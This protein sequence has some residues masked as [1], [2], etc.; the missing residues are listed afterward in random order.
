MGNSTEI[1]TLDLKIKKRGIDIFSA[2]SGSVTFENVEKQLTKKSHLC[3]FQ[4]KGDKFYLITIP[5]EEL[6]GQ[7]E[8]IVFY[9]IQWFDVI[10]SKKGKASRFVVGIDLPSGE[11]VISRSCCFKFLQQNEPEGDFAILSRQKDFC[12]ELDTLQIE[13]HIDVKKQIDIWS[14]FIQAQELLIKKLQEPMQCAGSPKLTSKEEE[15]NKEPKKYKLEV[16]LIADKSNE[17]RILEETLSKEM[18]IG[19]EFHEDGSA[20]MTLDDILRGL[21]PIIKKYYS[22]TIA[23]DKKIN[24]ILSICP[25]LPSEI[26]QEKYGNMMD[27]H[28]KGINNSNLE[29]SNLR[30]PFPE[31]DKV[32]KD[33]GY[34]HSDCGARFEI[35]NVSDILSND[36]LE[37]YH[38]TITYHGYK[39]NRKRDWNTQ[40]I[41]L[42]EPYNNTFVA[43]YPEEYDPESSSMMMYQVLCY[44]YGKSN[45]KTTYLYKYSN[46]NLSH[47]TSCNFS[48]DEWT[49]ILKELFPLT[50]WLTI[51]EEGKTIH[52]DFK[53]KAEFI[54]KFHQI[55]TLKGFKI[56]KSPLDDDFK[57]KV[58]TSIITGKSL[59]ER[60]ENKLEKLSGAEFVVDTGDDKKPAVYIGKLLASESSVSKLVFLL[61]NYFEDDKKKVKDLIS[62]MRS[63]PDFK[64][65]HANLRGDEAKTTWLREAMDKLHETKS[66]GLNKSPINSNIKDFIFDSSKAKEITK[67][68]GVNIEDTK[69]YRDFDRSSILQLN[70]S[71]K[72]SVLKGLYADDLCMLQGPPGTGKTTVIAE[73]IW[74]LVRNSQ[75]LKIL[76]TSETNLA[77]DNALEKLMNEK[78][79]NPL[80]G[81]YIT[82]IKPVRFGK[83]DKLEEEGK[84]YSIESIERW[85]GNSDDFNSDYEDESLDAYDE[86]DSETEIG[87]V[88]N[89]D[90]IVASW[91]RRIASRDMS[92]DF[93]YRNIIEEWRNDLQNPDMEAKVRFK[94]AYLRHANVVGST[95]SSTGSP[96][97]EMNYLATFKGLNSDQVRALRGLVWKLSGEKAVKPESIIQSLDRFNVDLGPEAFKDNEVLKST[98]QDLYTIEFDTVIMDEASKATPPELLLPL[99][100]GRKSI[101]IGDHRQLPP[102]LN[103]R[104]FKEA[105]LDL[106]DENAK[107]LSEDIDKEFVETSQFKRLI[108]NPAVSPT[109]KSTF[110]LQYRMHKDINDVI[111]QFYMKDESGGLQCGLDPERMD[112]PDLNDPQSRYHG[113]NLPGFISP[114]IHTMW[115]NVDEPERND[116]TSKVNVSEIEAVKLILKLLRRSS[117]FDEY[118]NHWDSTISDDYKKKE[119][120]E[121]GIISFYGKQVKKMQ[122]E[123]RPVARELSIPI[124]LKTV[125][126][127]QGMERNIIIVST[128]RSDRRENPNGIVT[129][130]EDAGFAKSP[131]RLNVALSRARRLLIVVGNRDFFSKIRDKE[132]SYLYK[133]AIQEI[134]KSG[135]L[136]EYSSLKKI[137]VDEKD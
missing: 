42:P 31:A 22:D 100:F 48:H 101:I 23:R 5:V 37:K 50:E 57:F 89:D 119:E 10:P 19:A 29:I 105:L 4:R 118:M 70:D 102:M 87:P 130:N 69:E 117:G 137:V 111:S 59:K 21:D 95:C 27:F 61:P 123:V 122:E 1:L 11:N 45:V 90:N 56:L 128:V 32:L 91:M 44:I 17:Y 107:K 39:R 34:T 73:L 72:L 82:L 26:M 110:H 2:A 120:K 99:C 80:L 79:V 116:G 71:Q 53:D 67:Y 12:D 76:L 38:I 106:K 9:N 103:E 49:E 16:P 63:N 20:F 7:V 65:V 81:R 77:V 98:L 18:H 60:F 129:K 96:G 78:N 135:I 112:L 97:F 68:Q 86:E 132:G 51:G 124:R 113:L 136:V 127:F 115:V 108:L 54:D 75:D 94:D 36:I 6:G 28:A 83:T 8:L 41:L 74:Q 24:C 25:Y 133:N 30:I 40:E 114:E 52:F 134:N 14:K 35:V 84:R 109:I 125:D 131:E 64:T 58:N 43:N 92:D 104:S 126:K 93:R 85:A 88:N 46:S 13:E 62:F 121:I 66:W 3:Y 55:E 33:E 47:N 15:D